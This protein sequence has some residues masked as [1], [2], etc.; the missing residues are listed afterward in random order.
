MPVTHITITAPDERNNNK[1]HVSLHQTI[2]FTVF[3]V[4]TRLVVT[5]EFIAPVQT[6]SSN[7]C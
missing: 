3:P 4:E 6:Y 5:N 2:M 7:A 1:S